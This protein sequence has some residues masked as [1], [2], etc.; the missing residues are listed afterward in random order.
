MNIMEEYTMPR[1]RIAVEKIREIIRL[2]EFVN[3]SDRAISRAL[4]ISRPIVKRYIENITRAELDYDSIKTMD[5]DTLLEILGGKVIPSTQRYEV[6][7]SRFESFLT[8]L[9]KT[10][11]TLQQLWKEYRLQHPDGYRYSQF[12]Y[13][14]QQWRDALPMTMHL[15]HKAGD[16]MFA[17]F[18]GKKLSL[19]DRQTGELKEVEVFVA[20][21]AATQLTY[22]EA[23]DSQKK[24]D[25]IRVNQNA[26]HYFGGV[27]SAVVPDNLKSAV[28]HAS[29]YEPDINPEYAHFARHY[30]T[31]ILPARPNASRDK[32]LVE[33]AVRIVYTW[34]FAS[35]RNRLFHTLGELN[36]AIR[37]ELE[38]YNAKP[39]QKLKISRRQQFNEIEKDRLKPLPK[40]KYV[41][42]QFKR[43][44]VQF[45]YH[46]LIWEDKHYYSV[47]Y[48]FRR[49]Q[50]WVVYTDSNVEIYLKNQRIAFHKR[51][52]TPNGYSTVKEHMPP[53]H[54]FVSDWSPQRFI[55]WAHNIGE[56]VQAMIEHILAQR[57]HPEQAYKVCLGILNLEKKYSRER[58][59]KACQRALEFHL[60]SYKG[61]KN[62]L[63]K[64]LEDY[65]QERFELL[66]DHQNLRGHHYYK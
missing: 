25:W 38:K 41:I 42:R 35:L 17:D 24:E 56:P 53:H 7:R 11:V 18:T 13:H 12:C 2:K 52:R 31:V 59:N 58:V 21:L 26:F 66:P 54:Q 19:V 39:M 50:V 6:L 27:P 32:A 49:K 65:Q 40:D 61:I 57:P 5:D 36:R 55:N 16:K 3:L 64:H 37:E 15:E 33:G 28:T 30:N 22:V 51:D 47:P 43:L 44:K 63:D 34:I 48:R 62:I 45:N 8:E 46:V 1:R 23:V 9:K 14:F 60:Y 29:K 10:G 4:N 20:L